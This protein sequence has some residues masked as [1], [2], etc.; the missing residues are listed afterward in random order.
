M[1]KMQN[2]TNQKEHTYPTETIDL[3]SGGRFYSKD[4]ALSSGVLK[5]KIPTAVQ[6]DI[7]TS[8]NLI[9]KG[10]VIDEF[11]KSIIVDNINYDEI[12]LG[13]KNGIL[14][15]S[16]I[17]LYGPKYD[18]SLKCPNCSESNNLSIDISELK[19]KQ[20][21]TEKEEIDNNFEFSFTLPV[22][23]IKIKFKLLRNK[24][25]YDIN[26]SL[27]KYKKLNLNN[28]VSSEISTRLSYII[29]EI[30]GERNFQK[31]EK[32]IRNEMTSRDSIALRKKIAEVTPGIDTN[33]D[34]TCSECGYENRISIPID[35]NFFWPGGQA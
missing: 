16:R 32:F 11:L 30:N 12:L 21:D 4:S 5:L 7:L 18:V 20:I 2:I 34:F 13:D 25:E 22:S 24:D 33:L 31:T 35:V 19:I 17:L 23:K 3:P 28:G 8:R 27:K 10:I 29:T 1:E 26:S 15:A 14:I 6:E 9:Q